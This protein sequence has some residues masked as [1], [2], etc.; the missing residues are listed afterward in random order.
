MMDRLPPSNP[1]GYFG[2]AVVAKLD[3]LFRSMGGE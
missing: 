2:T 1:Q 3:P